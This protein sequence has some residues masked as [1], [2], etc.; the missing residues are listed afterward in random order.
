M[1]ITGSALAISYGGIGQ[2]LNSALALLKGKSTEAGDRAT[3]ALY[4][5][6]KQT[7]DFSPQPATGVEGL[8]LFKRESLSFVIISTMASYLARLILKMRPW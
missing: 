3:Q 6:C 8:T 2:V 1:G 7:C 5:D 4:L